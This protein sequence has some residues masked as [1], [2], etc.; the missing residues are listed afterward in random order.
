MS[1]KNQNPVDLYERNFEVPDVKV[2]CE[3]AISEDYAHSAPRRS[4][5]LDFPSS[6]RKQIHE[7]RKAR[8]EER[9][10]DRKTRLQKMDISQ[11]YEMSLQSKNRPIKKKRSRNGAI[12]RESDHER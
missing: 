6:L 12:D 7:H 11:V 10:F 2:F 9:E 3:G 8:E 5:P 1:D 4:T